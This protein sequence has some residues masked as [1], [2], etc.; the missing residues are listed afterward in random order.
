MNVRCVLLRIP[1][2]WNMKLKYQSC[3]LYGLGDYLKINSVCQPACASQPVLCSE[4]SKL[5]IVLDE[6]SL[7][8]EKSYTKIWWVVL[9]LRLVMDLPVI[10]SCTTLPR[11]APIPEILTKL[12]LENKAE[13]SSLRKSWNQTT[14][15]LGG[16]LMILT[17]SKLEF[18]L[19]ISV[20]RFAFSKRSGHQ[21]QRRKEKRAEGSLGYTG[22]HVCTQ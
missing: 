18:N 15:S 2:V 17:L 14:M 19:T 8:P 1:K 5:T 11:F 9:Q 10:L 12:Q 4:P 20:L 21:G 6:A 13:C 22:K 3:F 7:L 16:F